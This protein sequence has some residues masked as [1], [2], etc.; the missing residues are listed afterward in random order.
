MTCEDVIEWIYRV[1]ER[2]GMLCEDRVLT[3]AIKELA[4]REATDFFPL[5]T[6]L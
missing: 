3:P 6:L 4:E 5:K 1:E 2:I